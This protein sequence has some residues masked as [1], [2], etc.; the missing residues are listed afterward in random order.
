MTG[1]AERKRLKGETGRGERSWDAGKE[2]G[3]E[4]MM[5]GRRKRWSE[6]GTERRTLR[7]KGEKDREALYCVAASSCCLLWL[8]RQLLERERERAD[9]LTRWLETEISVCVCVSSLWLS[10]GT[11][12]RPKT[13]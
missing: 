7:V 10:L 11:H 2:R 3:R 4:E 5:Q 1:E 9:K 6:Y 8:L 13:I 12:F